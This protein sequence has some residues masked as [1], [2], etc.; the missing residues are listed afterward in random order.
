LGS[1]SSLDARQRVSKKWG[2]EGKEKESLY[3]FCVGS[4]GGEKHGILE[5]VTFSSHQKE[6]I[7]TL[8]GRGI[9]R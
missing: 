4:A 2:R 6:F 7:K 5:K 3:V 8:Q 9:Q 1:Y